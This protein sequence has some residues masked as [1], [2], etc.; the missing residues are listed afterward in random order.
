MHKLLGWGAALVAV[1]FFSVLMGARDRDV[2]ALADVTVPIV[3]VTN[4]VANATY[5]RNQVVIANYSCVDNPGGSGMASCIGTVPNGTPI[6]TSTA[7]SHEFEVTGTDKAG[8]IMSTLF[9]YDVPQTELIAPTITIVNPIDGA[10]FVQ[11]RVILAS[12]SCADNPGGSGIYSCNGSV[13]SGTAIDTTWVGVHTFGVLA[14]DFDMNPKYESVTYTV[15]A[16]DVTP[17]V[18]TIVTPKP[19]AIYHQNA[20]IFASYSCADNVGGF[21][22]AS[23]TGP[24][25]SG[26]TLNTATLGAHTF[27][28]T[29]TD[30]A[31]NSATLTNSYT[32]VDSDLIPPVVTIDVPAN[33]AR[34]V[35]N[36]DVNSSYSC[37]DEPG[38]SGIASCTGPGA[39]G[40]LIDTTVLGPQTFT[41]TGTDNKGNLTTVTTQFTVVE[42][43]ETPPIVSIASPLQGAVYGQGQKIT[44]YYDCTDEIG[45]AAITDTARSR[46]VMG[47]PC[48]GACARR[49]KADNNQFEEYPEKE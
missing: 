19:G 44:A 7:G 12:Y 48:W 23:C 2:Q 4:P 47:Q 35:Q 11:N 33:G 28:V 25:A 34:Y 45:G 30:N 41:V 39:S 46:A 31:A 49:L 15:V 38:G 5:T 10:T 14:K 26:S 32:V 37:A 6:D 42:T 40:A 43:D 29:G 24:V 20:A 13:A 27:T 3:T 1:V 8:N 22:I 17:P 9:W 16:P 18:V 36:M 21:V